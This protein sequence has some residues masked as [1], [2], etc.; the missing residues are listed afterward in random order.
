MQFRKFTICVIVA[1]SAALFATAQAQEMI[2]SGFMTDYTQLQKVTDGSADYRY[3][4]PGGEDKMAQYNAVMI[5][6]PEIFIAND[7]PYRGAK[8]KHLDAFAESLRGGIA[9]AL[10]ED[11]YVV[12]HPGESVLYISIAAT[13]LKLTKKKRGILGYTP[14]GLVG[15]ALVGAAS[16][17]LAKK[18]NLQGLVFELE[19]FDSVSGERIIALIDSI[20]G[21]AQSPATW[22]ELE[23]FMASYG[24][25]MQ[26]RF[27]NARLPPYTAHVNLHEVILLF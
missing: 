9:S 4:A 23:A 6:Q 13:N 19:G 10:S 18:A 11:M 21:D 3:V 15:G 14:A 8:P 5:D 25:L 16:S 26:C 12:D 7:S 2:Y 24:R 22:E 17:D 1:T 20:G 27:D